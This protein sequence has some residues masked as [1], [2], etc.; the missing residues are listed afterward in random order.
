MCL[1]RPQAQLI[2]PA[3]SPMWCGPSW[4]VHD[5]APQQAKMMTH[6]DISSADKVK[7]PASG[8]VLTD[9]F[10]TKLNY[11]TRKECKVCAA[12]AVTGRTYNQHSA[13]LYL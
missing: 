2:K 9:A 4:G 12:L 13:Y 8:V 3:S 7:Q 11:S 10:T 5:V 6:S 1:Y